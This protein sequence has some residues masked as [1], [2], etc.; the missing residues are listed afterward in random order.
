[1]QRATTSTTA[2]VGDNFYHDDVEQPHAH[3][4]AFSPLASPPAAAEP[5]T[6]GEK[7]RIPNSTASGCKMTL[8]CCLPHL[9]WLPAAGSTTFD[10]RCRPTTLR[11]PCSD[12]EYFWEPF[13]QMGPDRTEK[14][15]R[16]F[17]S[18]DLEL[19]DPASG[20]I[21]LSVGRKF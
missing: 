19:L 15:G 14:V 18:L 17:R 13:L 11:H 8:P 4:N 6:A 2:R 7:V 21:F 3:M 10:C 1:M 12:D 16:K 20:E 9:W 5:C